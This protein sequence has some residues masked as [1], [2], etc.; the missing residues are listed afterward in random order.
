MSRDAEVKRETKET[1]ITVSVGLD[2]TGESSI[3]TGVAFF[4]HMLDQLAKHSGINIEIKADG[5]LE[6]DAHHT[7]ED[8]GI[9]LGEAITEALS[10]RAGISR[11]GW[12]LVPM[13]EALASVALDISGRPYLAYKVDVPA[14]AVGNYDP[15]LTEEF[16]MALS[17][18]AGL[19]LH[20]TQLAGKNSHHIIECVF[21]ATARALS[22]AISH[23][24]RRGGQ[25]PS[26]KGSL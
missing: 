4:D 14:E 25:I 2:G 11:Y 10:D 20:I 26:T 5:D 6:V 24:A 13:E 21:K 12:S 3:T 23:E 9:A 22:M 17:R 15:D 16:F 8:V 7:V 19:T 1:S 18:S